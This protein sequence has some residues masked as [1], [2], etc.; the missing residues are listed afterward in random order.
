MLFDPHGVLRDGSSRGRVWFRYQ[1]KMGHRWNCVTSAIE[2]YIHRPCR[3]GTEGRGWHR[4]AFHHTNN[5][6]IQDPDTLHVPTSSQEAEIFLQVQLSWRCSRAFHATR[7]G[8]SLHTPRN[9]SH[10]R[11]KYERKNQKRILV[12]TFFFRDNYS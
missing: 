12:P 6:G 4:G 7:L 11:E 1:Q 5:R 8:N 3:E 10:P 2:A 9:W